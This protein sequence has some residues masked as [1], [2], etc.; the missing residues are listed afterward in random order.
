MGLKIRLITELSG[1]SIIL[2]SVSLGTFAIS[3][4][5]LPAFLIIFSLWSSAGVH[6]V[7]VRLFL[8]LGSSAGMSL[9]ALDS[10]AGGCVRCAGLRFREWVGVGGCGNAKNSPPT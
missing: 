6:G 10:K 7:L 4:Q 9:V 5:L 8:A 2:E 1:R 3:L